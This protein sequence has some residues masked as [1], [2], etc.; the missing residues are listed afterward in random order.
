MS[1]RDKK[2]GAVTKFK[3]VQLIHNPGVDSGIDR[4]CTQAVGLVSDD[5]I[6]VLNLNGHLFENGLQS[7]S[8]FGNGGQMFMLLIDSGYNQGAFCTDRGSRVD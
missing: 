2:A 4:G 7:E 1:F 6:P 5:Q 3:T 8:G